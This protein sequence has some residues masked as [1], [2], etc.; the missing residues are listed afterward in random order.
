M[1]SEDF[2]AAVKEH[3]PGIL[4]MSALLT[5]TMAEQQRVI[6]GLKKEKVRDS[7]VYFRIK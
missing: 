2:L 3:G 6:E 7:R 1:K 4:A 5:T